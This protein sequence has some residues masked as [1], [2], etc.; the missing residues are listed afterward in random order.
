MAQGSRAA[1]LQIYKGLGKSILPKARVT[2]G[3]SVTI[4][5]SKGVK[6]KS[7]GK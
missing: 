5:K 4:T 2:K 6:C 7:C 3:K 1:K